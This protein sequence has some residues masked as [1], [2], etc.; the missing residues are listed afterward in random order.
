[1]SNTTC[2]WHEVT[3]PLRLR[4]IPEFLLFWIESGVVTRV[5][6][7]SDVAQPDIMASICKYVAKTLVRQVD[8][9]IS[10]GANDPVLKKCDCLVTSN[11]QINNNT[12]DD[13]FITIYNKKHTLK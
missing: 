1:M 9:P 5:R 8:H 7:A 13:A 11:Y 12:K 2:K 10:T 6:I 4:E 3:A